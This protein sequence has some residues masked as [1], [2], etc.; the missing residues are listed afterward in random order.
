VAGLCQGHGNHSRKVAHVN[1]ADACIAVREVERVMGA[2]GFAVVGHE[3]LHETIGAN[4]SPVEA[5]SIN[6]LFNLA[7][8]AAE[9]IALFVRIEHREFH[10][11]LHPSLFRFLRDAAFVL[12]LGRTVR[13]QKEDRVDAFQRRRDA[14]TISI[15][16][17]DGILPVGFGLRGLFR[18]IEAGA[19]RRARL[20]ELSQ[21]LAA[22]RPAGSR[23][24]NHDPHLADRSVMSLRMPRELPG[25]HD[26]GKNAHGQLAQRCEDT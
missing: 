23:N 7:M 2:Y 22:D 15:V 14:A 16:E 19:G 17:A 8:P 3:I 21:N 12:D 26:R 13:A 4:E 11:A 20:L 5:Q 1:M 25:I 18:I 24:Q 9:N 10:Q 6:V